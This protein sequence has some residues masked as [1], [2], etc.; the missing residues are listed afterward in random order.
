MRPMKPTWE[1]A[2]SAQNYRM[3]QDPKLEDLKIQQ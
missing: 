3:W 2:N 1:V